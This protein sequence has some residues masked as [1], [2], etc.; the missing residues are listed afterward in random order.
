MGHKI[1]GAQDNKCNTKILEIYT[2]SGAIYIP[3]VMMNLSYHNPIC[4]QLWYKY[5]IFLYGRIMFANSNAFVSMFSLTAI[6]TDFLKIYYYKIYY[7]KIYIHTIYYIFIIN[8][9]I[10]KKK[11]VYGK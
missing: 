5:L 9:T 3:L 7:S 10:I 2:Y 4:C 8:F 6:V 11:P 1:Y